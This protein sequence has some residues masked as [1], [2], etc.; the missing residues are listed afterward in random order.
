LSL[1]A[2]LAWLGAGVAAL[3]AAAYLAYQAGLFN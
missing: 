1:T 2:R 3:A